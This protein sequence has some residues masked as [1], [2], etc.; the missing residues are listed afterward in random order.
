MSELSG[1]PLEEL[2]Q[3][4]IDTVDTHGPDAVVGPSFDQMFPEEPSSYDLGAVVPV[5]SI[6]QDC[7]FENSERPSPTSGIDNGSP[8]NFTLDVGASMYPS[9][10][11]PLPTLWAGDCEFSLSADTTEALKKMMDVWSTPLLYSLGLENG[12]LATEVW[13]TKWMSLF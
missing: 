11:Q 8:S 13:C 2:F 3:F 9:S 5:Q 4:S 12:H 7:A 1:R 10:P 6:S